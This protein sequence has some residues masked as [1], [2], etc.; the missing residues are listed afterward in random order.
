M[1]KFHLEAARAEELQGGIQYTPVDA[2]ATVEMPQ[3]ASQSA[4]G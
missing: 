3:R 1:C 4:R 2:I